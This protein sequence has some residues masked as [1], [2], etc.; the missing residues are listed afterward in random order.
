M[1]V[2]DS[3]A[4]ENLVLRAE[5][6]VHALE[7]LLLVSDKEQTFLLSGQGDVIEPDGGVAAIGSGGPYA[8][9]AAEALARHTQL[10]ARQIAEESMK[11]AGK[12]CIYTNDSVTIEEL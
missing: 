6:V 12:M 9:A 7:A 10:T 11:I 4:D 3:V 8:Q 2:A 5:L 1:L